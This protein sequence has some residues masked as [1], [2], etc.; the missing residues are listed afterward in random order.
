MANQRNRKQTPSTH[1][2]VSGPSD[3][4]TRELEMQGDAR[5]EL[6]DP[7][8]DRPASGD[9]VNAEHASAQKRA[10]EGQERFDDMGTPS[11]AGK[12]R[13]RKRGSRDHDAR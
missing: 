2:M 11:R 3:D 4:P 9:W 13:N 1:S 10:A 12:P 6:R 8:E 5:R 7:R